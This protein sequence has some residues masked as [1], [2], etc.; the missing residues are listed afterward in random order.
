MAE[1]VRFVLVTGLS[2]AGKTQ[3][4]RVLEDLG[5]YCV[6]NLPP[7]LVP[8]FAELALHAEQ[9]RKKIAVCVDARTGE[10][11]EN[12]PGFLDSVTEMGVHP[13]TLFLES[14]DKVLVQRY[15]ES[16]RRHPCSPFGS[17]EE[18]IEHERA[19]L[20]PIRGRADLVVDTSAISVAQL[21]ERV[22]AMFTGSKEM[23]ELCV[24]VLSFGFKF[25]LPPEADLV[26]DMRFLPNPYYE[27]DLRALTGN[28]TAVREFV[29]GCEPAVVF[30]DK[31]K[32]LLKFVMPKYANEP[33]SYLTIAVGC[34]G[35][36]HR[37]VVIAQELMLFLRD[38]KYDVR[39]R[40]RD[41]S[42]PVGG[43]V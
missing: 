38:L 3:A 22:A 13:D 23:R 1:G 37:S 41:L 32:S 19:L 12:L 31:I 25:G 18:G 28:E 9:P 24:T 39:L 29:L 26:F 11:L 20:A 40:H 21:R 2:G 17:I 14:S 42:R 7:S 30:L 16:R 8:T 34:T 35:G 6:D 15:S 4:L 5:Y 33:K 43:A 10:K 27:E 36:R